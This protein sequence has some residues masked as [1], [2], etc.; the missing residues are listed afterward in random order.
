MFRV[1][2]AAALFIPMLVLACGGDGDASEP[3]PEP[4]A[5]GS[6]EGSPEATLER[7]VQSTLMKDFVA[8]CAQ[9]DAAR[10][11]GKICAVFRG[12]RDNLRAYVLGQTFSEG[13]QWTILE[14]RS[15]QWNVASVTNLNRDIAALPG[16]PWPLRT[17]SEVVVVGGD[18]LNVREGPGLGMRAVDCIRDGTRIKLSAGPT[19]GD[20]IQWYQVEGRTGWVA[21]DYLRYPDA[22]Q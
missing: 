18:C 11:A 13:V 19:E 9:A 6:Q 22:L 5:A 3:T 16:I 4:T 20:R 10:D 12:E 1:V 21:G 17:G 14:Q 8:D 2:V 7:H 15:G